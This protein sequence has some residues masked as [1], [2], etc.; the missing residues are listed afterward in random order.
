MSS[1]HLRLSFNLR[2]ES[3]VIERAEL[4]RKA[5]ADSQSFNLRIESLVIESAK[6]KIV[7]PFLMPFQSQN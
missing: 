6:M 2:I 1:A 5:E 7:F 3:L 4:E